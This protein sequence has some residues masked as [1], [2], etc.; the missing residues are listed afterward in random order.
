MFANLQWDVSKT[1]I[2]ISPLRRFVEG[3]VMGSGWSFLPDAGMEEGGGRMEEVVWMRED[4][5]EGMYE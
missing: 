1:D 3:H 5:G 2:Q 4:G